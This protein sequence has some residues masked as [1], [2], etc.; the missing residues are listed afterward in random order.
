MTGGIE[1]MLV[2]QDPAGSRKV[3]EHG[4]IDR[5]ARQRPYFHGITET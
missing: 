5:S 2:H 3:L 1:D 4:A